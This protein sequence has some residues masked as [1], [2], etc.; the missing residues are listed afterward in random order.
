MEFRKVLW[1]TDFSANAEKAMPYVASLGE[2]YQMEVHVLYVIEELAYHE[3][4]YGVFEEPHIDKIREWEKTTETGD[5]A[6]LVKLSESSS[7]F[8]KL[9]ARRDLCSGQ[10]CQQDYQNGSLV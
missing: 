6:E 1:P 7:T 3:P 8:A 4:W 10:K 2:K 9:D 5:R